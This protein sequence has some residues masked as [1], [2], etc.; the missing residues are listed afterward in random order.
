MMLDKRKRNEGIL[1]KSLVAVELSSP[2]VETLRP[3][4]KC[5]TYLNEQ[6]YVL[7]QIAAKSE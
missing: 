7:V 3:G 1:N 2:L 5:Q 6:N 4:T